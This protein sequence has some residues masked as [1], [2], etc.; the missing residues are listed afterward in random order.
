M[1]EN[2]FQLDEKKYKIIPH[3][4]CPT[5]SHKITL[6][7]WKNFTLDIHD[8]T[9]NIMIKICTDTLKSFV[10]SYKNKYAFE[11]PSLFWTPYTTC[12]IR[13]GTM[14]IEDYEERMRQ[15]GQ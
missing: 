12:G 13:I 10:E 11:Q 8:E 5:H 1:L 3:L 2:I 15:K 14:D 4:W 7:G 9:F 6:E